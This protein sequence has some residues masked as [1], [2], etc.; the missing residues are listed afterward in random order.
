VPSSDPIQRF[1]DILDNIGRIE[2]FTAGL[3][4]QTFSE[5][6]QA[7]FAVQHAL[8]IISEAAAKLGDLAATLCPS[9]P[10]RDIR[11]LGN[12][13]RHEYPTIAVGRLWTMIECDLA[14][15][16]TAAQGALEELLA[17]E[18]KSQS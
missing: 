12:R 4:A 16:K 10:W 13:L 14:P 15:L 2:R 3:N 6:E 7:L 9:V 17:C 5:N 18:D 11:G 8:L 1:Q